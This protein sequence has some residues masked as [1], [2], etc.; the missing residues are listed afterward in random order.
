M[1]LTTLLFFALLFSSS[2][3]VSPQTSE[4]GGC[5]DDEE[6]CASWAVA[7]EC[8][9]NYHYM[10]HFCCKSCQG[11]PAPPEPPE[12][13]PPPP[14]PEEPWEKEDL[15][16]PYP[17]SA[18]TDVDVGSLYNLS[19]ESSEP[20]LCWFYAPWCKQ[21]KLVRPGFEA[22][23]S[24]SL[25]MG[26]TFAKL[27]VIKHEAAKQEFGVHSYPALKIFRDGRHKWL[28]FEGERDTNAILKTVKREL[29]GP[30]KWADSAKTLRT[31]LGVI[32]DQS[33]QEMGEIG[34]GEALTIAYLP[35]GPRSA[36]AA[37]YAKLA[38][39]CSVR[40]NPL[41]FVAIKD[42]DLLTS[43]GIAS[44]V[45]DFSLPSNH[46]AI[47]K[48]FTE[49]DGPESEEVRPRL[50]SRALLPEA[51]DEEELCAWTLGHRFPLLIDFDASDHW[52]MRL[53]NLGF[54][55]FHALLFLSPANVD[56][57]STV[58]AAAE[59]FPRGSL[60]VVKF[61]FAGK[62]GKA[63]LELDDAQMGLFK[64]FGVNSV[65]DTPKL[66]FLDQRE[67]GDNRQK[68]YKQTSITEE[69][70]VE[71][72]KNEGLVEESGGPAGISAEFDD[73]GKDEL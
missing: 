52:G 51:E 36:A 69:G 14:P 43:I 33:T 27:D 60:V 19:A 28:E 3:A 64:R 15:E 7:G 12:P 42:H 32:F 4:G 1:R 11:T 5:T 61:L 34:R 17:D 22:A 53:G 66:V 16:T 62:G 40:M 54:Y 59:R 55:R 65:F 29:E 24:M 49:T 71:F 44:N 58:R 20:V 10:K 50:V 63:A 39:G 48:N 67:T 30:F 47:L 6:N 26:I 31:A 13:P 72:L 8:E 46:V 9:N 21:C 23:A 73:G 25:D 56:L 37:A 68:K 35:E 70:V 18:V 38:A 57:A 2:N 41:N 45:K